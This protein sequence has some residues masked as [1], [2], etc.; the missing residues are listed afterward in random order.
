MA[1]FCKEGGC[2]VSDFVVSDGFRCVRWW[3]DL[4]WGK[5]LHAPR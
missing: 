1:D 3:G 4:P 2:E 5:R